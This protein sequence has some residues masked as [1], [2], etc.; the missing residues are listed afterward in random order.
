MPT[1]T[2]T[3]ISTHMHIIIYRYITR[4]KDRT[5]LTLPQKINFS[6]WVTHTA[7]HMHN[8]GT[9]I[10]FL[11]QF[12]NHKATLCTKCIAN[13]TLVKL[14]PAVLHVHMCTYVMC[15]SLYV[16]V[17]V[18]GYIRMHVCVLLLFILHTITIPLTWTKLSLRHFH[19]RGSM[20][21]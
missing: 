17:C 7:K 14:F 21:I 3:Q 4:H 8:P 15:L 11:E 12:S 1:Y 13:C 19:H 6:S 9:A 16:C 18:H 10:Y 2:K 5:Q 20:E